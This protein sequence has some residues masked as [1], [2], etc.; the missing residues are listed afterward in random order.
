[1]GLKSWEQQ[2]EVSWRD[3]AK[4][5]GL[6]HLRL[7]LTHA[8]ETGSDV[9]HPRRQDSG[10]RDGEG[11]PGT[12][13]DF[14]GVL[15]KCGEGYRKRDCPLNKVD[16]KEKQKLA[17]GAHIQGSG[18]MAGVGSAHGPAYSTRSLRTQRHGP[19]STPWGQN[20]IMTSPEVKTKI[21]KSELGTSMDR[22][23]ERLRG[24]DRWIRKQGTIRRMGKRE[25]CHNKRRRG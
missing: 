13:R 9:R 8:M 15:S 5:P 17:T 1:M 3:V 20:V 10:G 18:V 22:I 4:S 6:F 12:S 25:K 24:I 11:N 23:N 2:E 7:S 19:R 16:G 21:G 14:R